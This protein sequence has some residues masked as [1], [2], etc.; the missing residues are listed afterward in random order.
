MRKVVARG[1][2]E[3]SVSKEPCR[4]ERGRRAA[5]AIM[6]P[7][8]GLV[9]LRAEPLFQLRNQLLDEPRGF[10]IRYLLRERLVSVD[11]S[12]EP[13]QFVFLIHA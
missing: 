4:R 1:E 7:A 12:F 9:Q 8:A 6:M 11:R 13:F 2:C 3:D 5:A 10:F